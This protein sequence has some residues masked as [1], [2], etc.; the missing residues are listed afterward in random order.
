[1]PVGQTIR[2]RVAAPPSEARRLCTRLT[3]GGIPAEV[4]DG[5]SRAEV[6]VAVDPGT[7][8]TRFRG[9][10]GWL[11][12]LGS[13]GAAYFAAGADDVVVPG[14]PELLFRRLRAV[15]EKLDLVSR[16]ERLN[17][18]V[19]ALEAGLADAAHDVRSPLQAVIGNAELLARDTSLTSAQRACAAACARQ[20][21]R[22]MQLAERILEAAKQRS[23]D[24]LAIGAVDLGGLIEAAVAQAQP[25]AKQ[26]GVTLTGVPPSRPVE[27]RADG[28]LLARVLDNLI[29]NAIRVSPRGGV[30]EVEAWRASPRFVRLS[31]KDQGEGIA[32]AEL[33][34]LI[35]GLG[36]GRG[37]RIA[38]EIAERH[39]GEIWAESSAGN[40]TRFFIELPLHPPSSRPSVLLVSDDTRWLREVSRTLKSA[41]DVR[42]ATASAARI[43]SKHTD[44][45]LLD[46]D[47]KPGK[48]LEALRSEAKG[49]QVPV[50]E[51][52]SQMAAS[53]LARTL[54]HLAV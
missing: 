23:R 39:G 49:A 11:V 54:A 1:M 45:V 48:K 19:V 21:L 4:D 3:R 22:A 40:G 25:L 8:L 10:V 41:C 46:P 44:L 30:V 50:I 36:P 26:Q 2:V 24:V 33:P 34:K 7:D 43:G 12:V 13:P 35:A 32:P 51:L 37:L 53:R 17:E 20:A 27:I 28:Q 5:T 29:A 9:R 42:T 18:R 6:L 14:E 47:Q 31:V 52:P 38:R 16:V 15:L